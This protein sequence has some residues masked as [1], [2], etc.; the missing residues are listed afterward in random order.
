MISANQARLPATLRSRIQNV[1]FS[2]LPESLI[3]ALAPADTEQWMIKACGGRPGRLKELKEDGA[4][5]EE[6]FQLWSE[7]FSHTSP[8]EIDF[9]NKI[10]DRK[11]A[12]TI[13]RFWLELLRDA[14]LYH[15]TGKRQLI[16]ADKEQTIAKTSQIPSMILNEWIKS[17]GRLESDLQANADIS[18]CFEHWAGG[19]QDGLQVCA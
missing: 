8:S 11:T 17:T 18:L 6:A 15:L 14:R 10:K 1:S 19:V 7:V 13:G 5:R 9:K 4:L 12:L 2:V 3:K 16:H